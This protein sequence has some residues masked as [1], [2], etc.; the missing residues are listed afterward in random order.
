[1]QSQGSAAVVES[2]IEYIH[3]GYWVSELEGV[4]VPLGEEVK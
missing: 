4:D 2:H 1:M 3:T